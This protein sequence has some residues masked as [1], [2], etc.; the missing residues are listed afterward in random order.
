MRC[1]H[2]LDVFSILFHGFHHRFCDFHR[3]AMDFQCSTTDLDNTWQSKLH[4][5]GAL[6]GF[7]VEVLDDFR[8]IAIHFEGIAGHRTGTSLGACSL[9]S[10]HGVTSQRKGARSPILTPFKCPWQFEGFEDVSHQG[11]STVPF[12]CTHAYIFFH[13]T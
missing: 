9:Q 7:L 2:M 10:H 13:L 1:E 3:F 5:T 6:N 12:S 4:Q 8:G 11:A